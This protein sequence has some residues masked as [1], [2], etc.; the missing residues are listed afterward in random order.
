M[1]TKKKSVN[2]YI[3]IKKWKEIKKLAEQQGMSASA[4]VRRVIYNY[5]D[6]INKK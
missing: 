3:D 4:F 5:L 1:V 6:K 2:V